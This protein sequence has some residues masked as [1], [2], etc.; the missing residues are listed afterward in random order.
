MSRVSQLSVLSG[1][2]W[3]APNLYGSFG[4]AMFDLYTDDIKDIYEC[5]ALLNWVGRKDED[6]LCGLFRTLDDDELSGMLSTCG[7]Y[8]QLDQYQPLVMTI[9][10]KFNQCSAMKTLLSPS[11]SCSLAQGTSGAD[12]YPYGAAQQSW[13]Y[14]RWPRYSCR[15]QYIGA[16]A[17]FMSQATQWEY[18]LSNWTVYPLPCFPS[19]SLQ[20]FYQPLN[21]MGFVS[22]WT[23]SE[24]LVFSEL[25]DQLSIYKIDGK[26][27][28]GL[29]PLAWLDWAY[30]FTAAD[31]RTDRTSCWNLPVQIRDQLNWLFDVPS[32]ESGNW[33][34]VLDDQDWTY[35]Y[36]KLNNID[37][38]LCSQV[39]NLSDK[40]AWMTPSIVRSGQDGPTYE[41]GNQLTTLWSL[42]PTQ[43]L[44]ALN[45]YNLCDWHH[46]FA[47]YESPVDPEDEE[48]GTEF[49]TGRWAKVDDNLSILHHRVFRE[50]QLDCYSSIQISGASALVTW[51]TDLMSATV[52][53]NYA[54]VNNAEVKRAQQY[55]QDANFAGLDWTADYSISNYW[56]TYTQM[57]EIIDGVQVTNDVYGPN[58]NYVQVQG[59]PP[60]GPYIWTQGLAKLEEF[61]PKTP[62]WTKE[63]LLAQ[64]YREWKADDTVFENRLN[65]IADELSAKLLSIMDL[66]LSVLQQVTPVKYATNMPSWSI[67]WYVANWPWLDIEY[68]YYISY[69]NIMEPVYD[70]IYNDPSLTPAQQDQTWYGI[71]DQYDQIVDADPT[72]QRLAA[73][74]Q[75][76]QDERYRLIRERQQRKQRYEQERQQIIDTDYPVIVPDVSWVADL[77]QLHLN[78]QDLSA[79]ATAYALTFEDC[80]APYID[81]QPEDLSDELSN[82][83]FWCKSDCAYAW[84]TAGV[85]TSYLSTRLDG[86]GRVSI[87]ELRTQ[88]L[89]AYQWNPVSADVSAWQDDFDE[90]TSAYI[91]DHPGVDVTE[92]RS[93]VAQDGLDNWLSSSRRD[94]RTFTLPPYL[95]TNKVVPQA[96]GRLSDYIAPEH[97]LA[98]Q[99]SSDFKQLVPTYDNWQ[100]HI[101][102]WPYWA[103]FGNQNFRAWLPLSAVGIDTKMPKFVAVVDS[104]TIVRYAT[105]NNPDAQTSKSRPAF[106]VEVWTAD[107]NGQP[108]TYCFDNV[109]FCLN[110]WGTDAWSNAVANGLTFTGGGG[111]AGIPDIAFPN[112]DQSIWFEEALSDIQEAKWQQW[113][114]Q[115]RQCSFY[116]GKGN[117]FYEAND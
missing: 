105:P 29:Y 81:F 38:C 68:E 42:K 78:L 64:L 99:V 48:S 115:L 92:A 102:N 11:M 74:I 58:Y 85:L 8:G 67:Q 47:G 60:A 75:S 55:V 97:L 98:R 27:L 69:S 41:V 71:W 28:K 39:Y 66:E 23:Q 61:F 59:Q 53:S 93:K 56:W 13:P 76:L 17:D 15:M 1:E 34:Y 6:K 12:I 24:G 112:N 5:D 44:F 113:P 110:P 104:T 10:Q 116:L 18:H 9:F 114:S 45:Y 46:T 89:S 43:R 80:K 31:L 54:L 84:P 16:W 7:W 51:H 4:P 57:T 72:I 82:F 40:Y 33:C 21:Q 73:D 87:C 35:A 37:W 95:E 107:D 96:P 26:L 62:Q 109:T 111:K 90:K 14:D 94:L 88:K 36:Q 63:E 106:R 103:P 52:S 83:D 22:G 30:L 70:D 49:K 25:S 101:G 65:D 117:M 79:E 108:M 3:R 2:H 50:E 77:A 20:S 19:C 91:E 32:N 100:V 86:G